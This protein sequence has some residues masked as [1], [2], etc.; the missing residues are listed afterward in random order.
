MYSTL[1]KWNIIGTNTK[2]YLYNYIFSF[3]VLYFFNLMWH[4]SNWKLK[5]FIHLGSSRALVY[6][7]N[8]IK[9][10]NYVI[11]YLFQFNLIWY[12]SNT[13]FSGANNVLSYYALCLVLKKTC[14]QLC[15]LYCTN[16]L[17]FDFKI[18]FHL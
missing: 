7:H 3:L 6:I 16:P 5:P 8:I 4:G 2:H 10:K 14:T 1:A 12:N 9:K 18:P 15:L 11:W 17:L 13:T